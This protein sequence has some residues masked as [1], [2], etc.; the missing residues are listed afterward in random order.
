MSENKRNSSVLS[1]NGLKRTSGSI[2]PQQSYNADKK[3]HSVINRPRKTE[4]VTLN[5]PKDLPDGR[6]NKREKNQKQQVKV[7]NEIK[8][9]LQALKMITKTKFDYEMV[10][11]LIDYY[12]SN[13]LSIVEQKKYKNLIE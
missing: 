9:E 10:E 13:E 3:T 1:G 8:N 4:E 2:M 5:L 11:L 12:V 6:K 7:S